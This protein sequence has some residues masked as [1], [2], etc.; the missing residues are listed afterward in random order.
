MIT[1]Q[2]SNLSSWSPTDMQRLTARKSTRSGPSRI[3]RIRRTYIGRRYF[4]TG[5]SKRRALDLQEAEEVEQTVNGVHTWI[6]LWKF[7]K[8][9]TYMY[10][11]CRTCTASYK[12]DTP[13]TSYHLPQ[14]LRKFWIGQLSINITLD[15]T[16]LVSDRQRY[17][18]GIPH[19]WLP[20]ENCQA[21]WVTL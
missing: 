18:A 2:T 4:W 8:K 20:M 1:S 12:K 11:T 3:R 9:M 17:L 19:S 14:I 10:V 7:Q 21:P 16:Q 5:S 15:P 13:I 6:P